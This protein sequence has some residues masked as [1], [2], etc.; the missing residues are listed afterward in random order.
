MRSNKLQPLYQNPTLNDRK[1]TQVNAALM[2]AAIKLLQDP[3]N[4]EGNAGYAP[5]IDTTTDETP[6]NNNAENAPATNTEKMLSII[7]GG[8]LIAI[9]PA[10]ILS[11]INPQ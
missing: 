10:I 9:L 4:P 6:T 11:I 8:I 7:I 2:Y 3:P 1:A 5:V